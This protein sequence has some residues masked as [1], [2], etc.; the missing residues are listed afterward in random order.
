MTFHLARGPATAAVV[1]FLFLL[2]SAFQRVARDDPWRATHGPEALRISSAYDPTWA[3][4]RPTQVLQ[5][6][7]DPQKSPQQN[8]AAFKALAQ[9][10]TPGQALLLGAGTWFVDSFFTLNLQGTAQAP[11]RIAGLPGAKPVITRSDAGQNT[12]NVG[13][14]GASRYLALQQLE[15][16]GGSVGLRIYDGSNIWVDRCHIHHCAAN[17]V[18]ANVVNTSHLYFTRNRV[19]DIQ[20]SGEGFY[21]GGNNASAVMRDSVIA[22]NRVFNTGGSQGDGIEIKQGSFNN[23]IADNVVHDTRY[24]CI[25][26]YGT[27]GNPPNIVERNICFNSSETVMQVQGEAIVRNNLLMNGLNGFSS[28]DHQGQTRDLTFVH[29]TII[30]SGR[31]ASLASWGGRPGMVFANNVVYSQ[32]VAVQFSSGSAGVQLGGNVVL[33]SVSGAPLSGF[34][35]GA[36]LADFVDVSWDALRRDAHPKPGGALIG[37]GDPLWAVFDDLDRRPRLLPLESGCYDGP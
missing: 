20:G 28:H 14:G 1:S 21:L 33:G 10:L 18:T 4:I 22:L 19:H 26:L 37:S 16:R 2:T 32:G 25:L 6:A 3:R 17:G 11:I 23:W 27:G 31:G 9:S 13:S 36:G 35:Q 7:Y 34:V 24:P 5:L 12:V 30:N 8:G 15:I 29:N